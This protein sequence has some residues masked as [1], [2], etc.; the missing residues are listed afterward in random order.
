[1]L[2]YHRED[3]MAASDTLQTLIPSEDIQGGSDRHPDIYIYVYMHQS[4]ICF[5]FYYVYEC[6]SM[7][8]CV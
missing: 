6:L 3:T 5:T 8:M 2:W 1:M 4:N 7:Y